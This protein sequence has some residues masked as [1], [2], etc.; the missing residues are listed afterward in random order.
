MFNPWQ[1]SSAEHPPLQ[2]HFLLRA[3]IEYNAPV[4]VLRLAVLSS[5]HISDAGYKEILIKRLVHTIDTADE[6]MRTPAMLYF[7]VL[8]ATDSKLITVSKARNNK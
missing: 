4:Y 2:L 8:R 1:L 3:A 5:P 6:V 7:C